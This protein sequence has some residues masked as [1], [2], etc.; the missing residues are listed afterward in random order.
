MKLSL[1][2]AARIVGGDLDHSRAEVTGFAADSRLVSKG[3]LFVALRGEHLD[4][5]DFVGEA[6][7]RGASGALMEREV[8]GGGPQ[9]LVDNT[10]KALAALASWARDVVDP[11]LAGI[12]GSTGK[13]STKDLL[14]AIGS[15]KFRVTASPLS[16][17]TEIGLPL[18]LLSMERH[19]ELAV[20]EMGARGPGQIA[21]LCAIAR[22]QVGIVTNVGVTHYEQFGSEEAIADAKAELVESLPEGGTAVLNADDHLVAGMAARASASVL[23]FGTSPAAWLRAER[24]TVD[25]RGRPTFRMARGHEGVWVSLS[26]S[27]LHQVMNALA[28]SAAAIALGISLDDCRAGLES[29]RGSPWRMEVHRAGDVTIVND[30]Y[31]ASPASVASALESCSAMVPEGGRL[32][33]VLGYM[34]EL[35]ELETAEHERVGGLTASMASRLV[36]V[37]SRAAG[38]AEGAR[39]SGM[40]AVTLVE[41]AASVTEALG[42]LRSGDVVLVKGSRVAGLESLAEQIRAQL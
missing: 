5:H 26:M 7:R 21:A 24:I 3:D 22:P 15:R 8:P 18:T 17:N 11:I 42:E 23:T 35:G 41:D 4:G 14:A 37:S 40:P 28:A 13:T 38:I 2:E 32:I 9:I 30:A 12:S 31:N 10:L 27:G 36:V 29:A 1:E 39:R 34:A 33:A 6:F 19:T 20:C 16:H 25:D